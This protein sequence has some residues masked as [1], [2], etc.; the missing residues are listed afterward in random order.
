MSKMSG[1]TARHY[2]IQ[3]QRLKRRAQ[4]RVLRTEIEARKA[5]AAP[6]LKTPSA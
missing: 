6:S 2:R 3:K 4:V 1:D 5:P